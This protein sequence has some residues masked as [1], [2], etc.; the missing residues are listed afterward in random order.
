M[1]HTQRENQSED[2]SKPKVLRNFDFQGKKKVNINVIRPIGYLYSEAF[3]EA[4][5]AISRDAWEA[6]ID[7]IISE[8]FM[9]EDR[10]IYYLGHT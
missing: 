6:G 3:R 4:A 5:E 9:A 1:V 2:M 7:Y 8:N 10:H